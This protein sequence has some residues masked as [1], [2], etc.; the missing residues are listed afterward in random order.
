[1]SKQTNIQVR[2]DVQEKKEV[3]A[4][5]DQLGLSMSQAIKLLLRQV[6]LRYALPFPVEL[7]RYNE[8]TEQAMIEGRLIHEN[9]GESYTLKEFSELKHK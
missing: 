5:L 8:E 2:L 3:E 7:R 9:H 1:M 6:K 4:I